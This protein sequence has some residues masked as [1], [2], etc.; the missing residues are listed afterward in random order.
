MHERVKNVVSILVLQ[1]FIVLLISTPTRAQSIQGEA[2]VTDAAAR[3]LFSVDLNTGNR[4]VVTDFTDMSQGPIG[5]LPFG[6]ALENLTHALVVD[7]SGGMINFGALFRV[8][9]AT[10]AREIV[11]DFGDISQGRLAINPFDVALENS[12]F[13]LVIDAG[14]VTT[15]G[16]LYR[17]NLITGTRTV[18]SDFTNSSFGPVGVNPIGITLENS[19]FALVI[20]QRES[21][22]GGKLFRGKPYFRGEDH[23]K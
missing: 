23:C 10:G 21:S 7:G 12:N 20:D 11:S 9:L 5:I 16:N 22:S 13:A 14:G 3:L 19:N 6:L 1:F 15:A 8:N 4:T 17:V 2:L 18:V